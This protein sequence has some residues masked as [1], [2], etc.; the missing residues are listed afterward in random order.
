MRRTRP[1]PAARAAIYALPG[2]AGLRMNA[3]AS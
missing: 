2:V 1:D 3:A